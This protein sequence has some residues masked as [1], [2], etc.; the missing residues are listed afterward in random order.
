MTSVAPNTLSASRW[1]RLLL[2]VGCGAEAEAVAEEDRRPSRASRAHLLRKVFEIEM[3]CPRREAVRSDESARD[4]AAVQ[5]EAL[6][7]CPGSRQ[8]GARA[9]PSPIPARAWDAGR[10]L[11]P[12]R[13]TGRAG[14]GGSGGL[15]FG[16]GRDRNADT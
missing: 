4:V 5:A 10:T 16:R 9:V 13:G 12:G 11:T 15:M 8:R 3:T 14:D 1:R 7:V 2:K 6:P